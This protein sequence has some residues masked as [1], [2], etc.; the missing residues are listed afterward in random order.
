MEM[1]IGLVAAIVAILG[2]LGALGYGGYLLMLQSV[3]KKRP[4]ASHLAAD[5]RRHL[6]AA[7]GLTLGALVA[8]LFTSGGLAP[9]VIGLLLGG[10]VGLVSVNQLQAARRRLANPPSV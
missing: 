4:G 1:V 2:L 10:G 6:P 3:A 5:A 9:D 7:G 8:L